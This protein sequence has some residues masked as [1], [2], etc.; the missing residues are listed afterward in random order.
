MSPKILNLLL[1]LISP[2]IYFGYLNPAYTG[3]P[4]LVWT[5]TNSILA[6]KSQ[7]VQY[8][9]TVNQVDLVQAEINKIATNYKNVPATTTEKLGILLPTSIDQIKL[10]N[11]I[12]TMAAK[13]GIA[14]KN[15]KIDSKPGAATGLNFYKVSFG[16]N[17]RYPVFKKFI[18]DYEKNMRFFILESFSIENQSN[19]ETESDN[20]TATVVSTGDPDVLTI[21]ISSRVYYI[22]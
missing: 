15:I 20:Q 13:H 4:G 2:V 1:I 17:A 12:I 9:N 14:V 11:E 19:K 21:S 6:L 8:V 18:E 22:K 10:R 5:P 7:N 3:A 16:M